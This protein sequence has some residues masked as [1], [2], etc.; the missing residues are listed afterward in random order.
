MTPQPV[1]IIEKDTGLIRCP[2]CNHTR[3][4][5]RRIGFWFC[6]DCDAKGNH[7]HPSLSTDPPGC[8]GGMK[9]PSE[10]NPVSCGWISTCLERL[11]R[12]IKKAEKERCKHSPMEIRDEFE[13]GGAV[14]VQDDR[15]KDQMYGGG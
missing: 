12:K 11:R 6:L 15:M 7:P 10:M 9:C 3:V 13:I 1:P 14:K 2:I 4:T 8:C 5:W